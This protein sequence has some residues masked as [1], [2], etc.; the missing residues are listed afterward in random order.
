M[1]TGVIIKLFGVSES[2]VRL[3]SIIVSMLTLVFFFWVLNKM[4]I[5]K[6]VILMTIYSLSVYNLFVWHSRTARMY[7][8]V[9]LLFFVGL[10][11]SYNLLKI[12]EKSKSIISFFRNNPTR[13]FLFISLLY[14]S[15]II[16][17]VTILF[18]LSIG[19]YAFTKIRFKTIKNLIFI[20]IVCSFSLLF[21]TSLFTEMD[22][23]LHLYLFEF[24]LFNPKLDFFQ[25]A[26]N[27]LEGKFL[28]VL[29]ALLPLSALFFNKIFR[30]KETFKIISISFIII[31]SGVTFLSKTRFVDPR[32]VIYLWPLYIILVIYGIFIF[33]RL[34]CKN[35][36]I[37]M[38]IFIILC[39]T[40][41]SNI[42][43]HN[44][45]VDNIIMN[46]PISHE[47][48]LYDY[49]RWN[50]PYDQVYSF[51]NNNTRGN[52]LIIGMGLRDYYEYKFNVTNPVFNLR[53]N[54]ENYTLK[55]I[56]GKDIIYVKFDINY[57]QQ[58]EINRLYPDIK[59]YLNTQDKRLIFNHD[60]AR[61][62][63]IKSK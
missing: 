37:Q 38:G 12:A 35:K 40:L 49:S 45:C 39:I 19:L 10:F 31:L 50:Y 4:K 43:I 48:T 44:I 27:S 26:Y 6:L 16:H 62:Y 33:T 34:F 18:L 3:P 60:R 52:E 24:N 5:N 14:L 46:C 11:Y 17:P 1:I 47:D 8:L 51:I 56:I 13:I 58:K 36:K 9:L 30:K 42:Q 7:N 61:V 23:L 55:S 32:Y 54:N 15:F 57:N 28:T 63:L 41:V 21:I 53:S 29:F 59:N 2:T 20:S 25:Y 22:N